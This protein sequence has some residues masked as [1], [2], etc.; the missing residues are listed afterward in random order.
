MFKLKGSELF[1]ISTTK[2]KFGN[3]VQRERLVLT[4][5]AERSKVIAELHVDDKGTPRVAIP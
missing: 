5:D 1:H 2:D 3:D 4:E